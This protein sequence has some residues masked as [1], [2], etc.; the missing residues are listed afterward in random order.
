M[1]PKRSTQPPPSLLPPPAASSEETDSGSGSEES[2]E[3]E[4]IAHSPPPAAPENTTMLLLKGH[5][6][7]GSEEEE[8]EEEGEEEEEKVNHVAPP[9]A[10][11]N[12]SPPPPKRE[13]SETSGDEE[14]ET[15]DDEQEEMDDEASQPKPAPI[16]KAEG[17]GAKPSSGEDK[18]SGAPFQRTWST[19]DEVRILEALAAY[20]RDHGTLPQVDAL[21]TALAGSLN[22]SSCSLKVLDSKI[23]SLKRRYTSA[24]Q[25]DEQPSKDHDRLLYDLS[26]SVWG[27][28]VAVANG[29]APRDFD[30]MCELY[31]YLAEEVKALQRSNQ[32]LFKREFAMMDEDKARSLD[33]KIKK[34]RMHQLR[35]HN[36]RHDLTKEVTK[37]LIELVD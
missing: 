21:A 19:D 37:T 33:A 15:G 22:N 7:E 13:E 10:T 26:K 36:R 11:K 30:E 6:S 14:E 24:S 29:G 18:K 27:H 5:V 2:E 31:P 16:Q 23:K 17:K 25:K 12:P 35:L 9:P 3:E 1:A 34:Q 32:G 4:E 28:V 20:R 8:G